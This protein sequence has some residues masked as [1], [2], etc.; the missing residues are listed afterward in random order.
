MFKVDYLRFTD[1]HSNRESASLVDSKQIEELCQ[2]L[3]RKLGRESSTFL[4]G[5]IGHVWDTIIS[6]DS[7]NQESG[8]VVLC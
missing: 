1:R 6:G 3:Q 5:L 8:H 2:T 4:C 7:L